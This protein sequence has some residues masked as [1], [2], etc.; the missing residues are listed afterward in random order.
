MITEETRLL[1]QLLGLRSDASSSLDPYDRVGSHLHERCTQEFS[2]EIRHQN[3]G[4]PPHDLAQDGVRGAGPSLG[5]GAARGWRGYSA[6]AARR[7][8]D[9]GYSSGARRAHAELH[10]DYRARKARPFDLDAH[11]YR[12]RARCL[13]RGARGAVGAIERRRSGVRESISRG[14]SR[15]AARHID[16]APH[17]RRLI[18]AE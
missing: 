13:R 1:T 4:A 9:A 14:A 11:R 7:R 17:G 15:S 6:T 12:A 16:G 10:W 8:Y 2:K 3:A 5:C 18:A